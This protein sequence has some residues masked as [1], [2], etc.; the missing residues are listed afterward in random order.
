MAG[1]FGKFYLFVAAVQQD[2]KGLGLLWLV[3]LAIATS[4]ISLYYYLRILKQVYVVEDTGDRKPVHAELSVRLAI[5]VL[6]LGVVILGC[7][8]G[9][10][11]ER[12]VMASAGAH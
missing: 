5:G 7:V 6:A 2:S 11:V 3:I 10:F 4:C 9:L 8:P 1:F 12:L